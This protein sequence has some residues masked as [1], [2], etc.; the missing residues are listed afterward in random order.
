MK[1]CFKI[2]YIIFFPFLV[3]IE[4]NTIL[5]KNFHSLFF[6]INSSL[7]DICLT[8]HQKSSAILYKLFHVYI[9][10]KAF[11]MKIEC[12]LIKK[13]FKLKFST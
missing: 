4:R 5:I 10:E 6:L 3:E 8:R 7:S 2:H 1:H 11:K 9:I 12:S 13:K